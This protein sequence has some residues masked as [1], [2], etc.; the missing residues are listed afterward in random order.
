MAV[1]HPATG[2]LTEAQLAAEAARHLPGGVGAAARYNPS[3]GRAL[4]VSRAAGCRIWDADGN[5]YIDF[6]LAHGAAFLGYDHPAVRGAYQRAIEMG[7]VSGYETDAHVELARLVVDTIP[8]AER[9]RYANTGS[10]GTMVAVR[11]ARAHTGRDKLLKFWGHFHGLYDYVMYNSHEPSEPVAAGGYVAPVQESAG[12]PAALDELVVVVPWKD[13]AALERA[14]AEHGD[15]IAGIIMEPINYNQGCIVADSSYHRFVREQA[16]AHGCVLIYDEVLS[17]YRT[18]PDCAQ[19]HIGVTPDLCVL[20]KAVAAGGPLAVIAGKAEVMKASKDVEFSG[21]YEPD[22][23]VRRTLGG[24][25]AYQGVHWFES[26]DEMLGDPS[27][28]AIAVEGGVGENLEF[29]REVL[30]SGK[31]VWLDKPPGGDWAEFGSQIQL[32]KEKELLVQLGYMFR[33]N[34]GFQFVLDWAKSGRLG[35]VFTVRARMSTSIEEEKRPG[36]SVFKGG[37]LFELL[38]HVMDIVVF[39]LGRPDKITSFLRND[40]SSSAPEFRDNTA[41]VFEYPKAMAILECAAVEVSPFPARRIE[42]YG[43]RGSV[44]FQ[45]FEPET[46]LRLCLDENRDGFVEGWQEV[47]LEFRP[48]YVASLAALVADIRGEKK[49]DRSLDHEL[50]VQETVLRAAGI[51]E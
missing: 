21:V 5:E 10:E 49:P 13:E 4:H 51:I 38:C 3:F 40:S 11:L 1:S 50:L 34:S 37:I 6:N 19:G 39:M 26:K 25:D 36:L 24:R 45:P 46:S 12:I 2:Q 29:S 7:V 9:V 31:H 43:T 16:T 42:I 48:R 20:G 47:A 44:L 28:V 27:I 8:C 35:E 22:P 30:E 33:Y 17:A 18:G 23:E 32:A 14:L 41:T 15:Q